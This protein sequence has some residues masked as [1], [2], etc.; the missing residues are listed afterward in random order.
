MGIKANVVMINAWPRSLFGEFFFRMNPPSQLQ[1]SRQHRYD[2]TVRASTLPLARFPG[3][4]LLQRFFS[5]SS[6]A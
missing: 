1:A 4:Q 3:N 6:I 5:F 2:A